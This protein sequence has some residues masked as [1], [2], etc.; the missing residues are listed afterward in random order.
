MS[1][2]DSR[3]KVTEAITASLKNFCR[4]GLPDSV[5]IDLAI[6]SIGIEDSI[7][8]ADAGDQFAKMKMRLMAA[9]YLSNDGS[10]H[11]GPMP[12]E[13]RLFAGRELEKLSKGTPDSIKPDGGRPPRNYRTKL[14]LAHWIYKAIKQQGMSQNCACSALVELIS[15][16]SSAEDK[17]PEALRKIY[18]EVLPDIEKLYAEMPKIKATVV[19]LRCLDLEARL[20]NSQVSE[21]PQ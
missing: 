16:G 20:N 18:R 3:A 1:K 4:T 19:P 17:S 11:F 13:L 8:Q 2:D 15:K 21:V 10:Y 7:R 9:C 14:W 6:D 12:N 5:C